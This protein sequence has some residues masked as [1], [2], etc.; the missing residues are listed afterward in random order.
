MEGAP[1]VPR[2]N[3]QTISTVW[4]LERV[5]FVVYLCSFFPFI[6]PFL[7]DGGGI[8]FGHSAFPSIILRIF[9]HFVRSDANLT[10]CQIYSRYYDVIWPMQLLMGNFINNSRMTRN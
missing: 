2:G 4:G 3:S 10:E 9:S 6:L 5:Q 8:I 1:G 7:F